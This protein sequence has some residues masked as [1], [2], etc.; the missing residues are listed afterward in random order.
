MRLLHL[1]GIAFAIVG[2]VGAVDLFDATTVATFNRGQKLRQ[3]SARVSLHKI[4]MPC[5]DLHLAKS[6]VMAAPDM[7]WKIS[8][9]QAKAEAQNF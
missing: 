4:V 7:P 8:R 6:V 1:V 5:H 3:I 9:R 2:S